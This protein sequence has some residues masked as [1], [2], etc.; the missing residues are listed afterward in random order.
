MTDRAL[1][2]MP[3]SE[4]QRI[5]IVKKTMRNGKTETVKKKKIKRNGKMSWEN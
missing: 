1:V 5:E 4:T 2:I 3:Y